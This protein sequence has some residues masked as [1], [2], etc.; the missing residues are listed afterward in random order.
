MVG[1][2]PLSQT[3]SPWNPSPRRT[4]QTCQAICSAC[5]C[6][7]MAMITLSITTPVRRWPCPT[8][9]LGSV[10][11]LDQHPTGHCHP[12]CL[13]VP[14]EEGSI[15]TSLCEQPQ[16][17]RSHQ[18][19]HH[20]LAWWHQGSSSPVMP[21]LATLWDP[22]Y[23]KWPCPMWRSPHHPSIRKGEDATTTLQVPSRESPKPICLHVD[24][25]S[26]QALTKP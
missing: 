12:P 23:W 3:T 17:A 1:L 6:A 10:H 7:S 4:W 15:P 19:D 26:G 9:S 21:I 11:V 2:L 25:S 22:H 8:H 18:H 20:W 16:Y 13:H 5:Y 14:R 24:V